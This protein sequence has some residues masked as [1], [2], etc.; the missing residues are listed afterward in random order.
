MVFQQVQERIHGIHAETPLFPAAAIEG[1]SL[2]DEQ[3]TAHGLVH[4]ILHVGL[5]V[6]HILADK[7]LAGNF[8]EL[9]RR[10]RTDGV[11]YLPELAGKGG[12]SGAGIAGKEVMILQ[13][14]FLH[15]ALFLGLDVAHNR[16][17]LILHALQADIIVQLREN[18][19]LTLGDE[20]FIGVD[21]LFLDGLAASGSRIHK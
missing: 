4:V 19:L 12:F 17:N 18:F 20:A 1:V 13:E 14:L 9:A 5:R 10:Q 15:P 2:V 21:I 16:A 7:V 11:E 3:H 6:A 8:H